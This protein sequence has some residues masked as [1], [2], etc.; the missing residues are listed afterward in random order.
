MTELKRGDTVTVTITGTVDYKS[1]DELSIATGND[2]Q[3]WGN[4]KF[5]HSFSPRDPKLKV[6]LHKPSALEQFEALKM[7]AWFKV[8]SNPPPTYIKVGAYDMITLT[9]QKYKVDV[10]SK[11]DI[12]EVEPA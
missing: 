11:Y 3:G 10:D 8:S 12:T 5:I 4:E 6:E 7:G 1:S 9:G 2:P